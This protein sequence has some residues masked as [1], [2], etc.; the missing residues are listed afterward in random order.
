MVLSRREKY[1]AIITIVIIMILVADRYVATPFMDKMDQTAIEKQRLI[2]EMERAE[3]LFERRSLMDRRWNDMVAGGLEGDAAK[4]ES[5]VLHAI[6]N[7]SKENGL[8]LSSVKPD[9]KTGE[10][11]LYEIVF[12]IAGTG[13]MNSVSRF[14]FQIEKST[15][16]IRLTDVQLGSREEDGNDLSLQLRLSALYLSGKVDNNSTSSEAGSAAGGSK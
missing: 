9:H 13:T 14:L 5:Q 3:T 10:D 8:M 6:G 4:A 7:W 2:V 11:E 1:I 12:Q 15:L 16:P